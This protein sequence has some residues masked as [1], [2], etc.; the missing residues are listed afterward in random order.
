MSR[1]PSAGKP[2]SPVAAGVPSAKGSAFPA[3]TGSGG[4]AQE[5]GSKASSPAP[6]A[7]EASQRLKSLDA[8]RGFTMLLMALSFDRIAA[9]F[10]DGNA[11]QVIFEQFE[12]R[13]WGGWSIW[14]MIQP[15]FSFMV[16]VSLPF[17]AAK[18]M[19]AG[20]SYR[21]VFLH[22]ATR[23]IILV[24]LGVFLRSRNFQ[25][26]NWTFVDTLSQIGL[27]YIFLFL[28]W[29]KPFKLQLGV[30]VLILVSYWSFFAFWPLPDTTYNPAEWGLNEEQAAHNFTGFAAHWNFNANP[31][32][33]FDRWFYNQLPRPI[34]ADGVWVGSFM[35][36]GGG[37]ALLNFIPTLATMILGLM[38]GNTLFSKRSNK[39]KLLTM[40]GIGI[41][42]IALGWVLDFTGACPI[43]KKIWTPSWVLFSGGIC[44]I[45]LATLYAIMDLAGF[46]RWAYPGIV[47]GM[48]PIVLYVL[49]A[50]LVGWII[51][52]LQSIFGRNV[53]KLFGESYEP[54][55]SMLA[56]LLV[57][58][59]ICFWMYRR[60][61]FIRI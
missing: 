29:G 52:R 1:S 33:Y 25:T 56:G 38:V 22:A 8:Y 23:A 53:F 28:L 34:N 5:P 50:L 16:G 45:V 7:L 10:P 14:D 9:H 2:N 51:D 3:N 12:H 57:L 61:I 39:Q 49:N 35:Y 47:V 24:L 54:L 15:S 6:T 18:R 21:R 59:L 40:I 20:Q 27:G 19:A 32:A 48:N 30:F 42:L 26:T 11:W 55:F 60:R 4:K 31:A 43:V 36:D 41:A 46:W 58:W 44:F 37:Y 17:S 13:R